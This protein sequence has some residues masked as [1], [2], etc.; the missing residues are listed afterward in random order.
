MLHKVVLQRCAALYRKRVLL[1]GSKYVMNTLS[2]STSRW[3]VS[4]CCYSSQARRKA[5]L[6][7]HFVALHAGHAFLTAYPI[8]S[9]HHPNIALRPPDDCDSSL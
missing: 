2:L 1:Q 5:A 7:M 9:D 8:T 4:A 3:Q 6:H